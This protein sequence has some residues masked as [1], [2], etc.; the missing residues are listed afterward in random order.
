[1]KRYYCPECKSEYTVNDD[2]YAPAFCLT[3]KAFGGLCDTETVELPNYETP[4]QYEKRTGKK[5]NGAV[6]VKSMLDIPEVP[7]MWLLIR[8]S[9]VTD[10]D[11]SDNDLIYL[12]AQSPEPPPDDWKPEEGA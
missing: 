6:W 2:M 9:A 10:E 8:G 12:C 1:M 7:K 4:E 11:L 5:W 3:Y